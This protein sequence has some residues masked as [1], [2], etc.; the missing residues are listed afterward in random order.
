M[1]IRALAGDYLMGQHDQANEDAFKE[2]CRRWPE[3]GEK[4]KA[5][6]I[7]QQEAA[8]KRAE[9]EAAKSMNDASTS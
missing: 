3:E 4:A 6:V 5:R 8:R 7:R 9:A 1:D 2:F